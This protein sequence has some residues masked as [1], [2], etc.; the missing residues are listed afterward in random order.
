MGGETGNLVAEALAWDYS[1]F[2]GKTLVGLEIEGKTRIVLLDEDTT[3]LLNGLG[4][5]T[6]LTKSLVF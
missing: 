6:T 2:T 4:T 5:D 3:G 1:D